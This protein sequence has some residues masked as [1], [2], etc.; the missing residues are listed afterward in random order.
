MAPLGSRDIPVRAEMS[1]GILDPIREVLED[2][3]ELVRW[4]QLFSGDNLVMS[5]RRRVEHPAPLGHSGVRA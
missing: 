1:H 2:V 4:Q 3:P 5:I